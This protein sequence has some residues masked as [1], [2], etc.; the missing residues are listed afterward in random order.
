[1]ATKK[2]RKTSGSSWEEFV[3]RQIETRVGFELAYQAEFDRLQL[4]RRIKALREKEHLSQEELA[5]RVP[6]DVSYLSFIENGKRV[7][8][9]SRVL[10]GIA[11]SLSLSGPLLAVFMCEAAISKGLLSPLSNTEDLD[12]IL[13]VNLMLSE[14][15][16]LTREQTRRT[17]R[18][19][20]GGDENFEAK[21]AS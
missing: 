17:L 21:L 15:D 5:L 14:G 3:Q 8:P 16:E 19:L 20:V 9:G 11:A 13:K 1:M 2:K 4:A 12:L 10:Y 7:N 18:E 6:M